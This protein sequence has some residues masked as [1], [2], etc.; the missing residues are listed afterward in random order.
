MG[1]RHLNPTPPKRP[2]AILLAVAAGLCKETGI[3]A[4]VCVRRA[5]AS[6]LSA[7]PSPAA[8]CCSIPRTPEKHTAEKGSNPA[9]PAPKLPLSLRAPLRTAAWP[10][11]LT[12]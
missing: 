8:E 10:A 3:L 4:L 9:L 11:R 5:A 6:L 12:L 1:Y 7:V 2:G